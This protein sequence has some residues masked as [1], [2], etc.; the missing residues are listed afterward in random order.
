MK[1]QLDRT[2][3]R[4]TLIV[5]HNKEK[6]YSINY[7][8]N[9]IRLNGNI[10]NGESLFLE[11][12]YQNKVIVSHLA[13]NN[14]LEYFYSL[15]MKVSIVFHNDKQGWK[16]SAN[17]FNHKNVYQLITVSEHIKS[18]LLPLTYKPIISIRHTVF[19]EDIIS[20]K[21]RT[22]LGLPENKTI[23]GMIGR[24]APQKDYLLALDILKNTNYVLVI[25]GGYEKE[26]LWYYKELIT[27]IIQLKLINQVIFKGFITN[28][29]D[30]MAHFDICLNTSKYEGLSIATQEMLSLNIPI[31]VKDNKG[32]REILDINNNLRFFNDLNFSFEFTANKEK[33]NI[34][35]ISNNS[36]KQWNLFNYTYNNK[37]EDTVFITQNL[38]L[39]GA[40]RSLVN[41]ITNLTKKKKLIVINESN[42]N[43]FKVELLE[44][45]IDVEYI[46]KRDVFDISQEL[47]HIISSYKQVVF[48]NLDPKIKLLISKFFP[49]IDIVDVSPGNYCLDEMANE[50][51]FIKAITYNEYDYFNHIKT[52]VSKY[53]FTNESF[54]YKKEIINKTV[55]IPNG[56]N[57]PKEVKIDYKFNNRIL[58][59]GRIAR[60]KYI[61]E[62]VEAIKGSTM[63]LDII[64]SVGRHE[65]D[66]Y[67]EIL[68]II[69]RNSNIT[70]KPPTDKV[71]STMI[72]YDIIIILGKNQGSPN[73][74]LEAASIGLPIIA[75]DS[76]GTKEILGDSGILLDKEFS[77]SE[78]KTS[79][80][81]MVFNYESY[82]IKANNRR[83][84]IL[85]NF[86][87]ELFKDSYEYLLDIK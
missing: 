68:P 65:S 41:L 25:L 69:K 5:L 34:K 80:L 26:N 71:Q 4:T 30:Y 22:D 86:S 58:L 29:R 2:K 15:D 75:N 60:S 76:G 27:K 64:G 70:I 52:F 47:F 51:D 56:V 23:I 11:I 87:I 44:N 36:I 39:G 3:G 8:V 48:W 16:N 62:I 9:I 6:E 57:K 40:Q 66:Y 82:A 24:I 85:N 32:Q 83:E 28:T 37:R 35:R 31:Y 7:T 59:L 18:Q 72:N 67:N 46:E 17:I 20:T 55:I 38:G 63:K 73:T 53:D 84:E 33:Y 19:I 45:N 12:A 14:T 42:Y 54:N 78:L 43:S 50:Q 13:S 61:L 77:V 81:Y 10:T 21:T 1:E 74:A 49:H 79:L